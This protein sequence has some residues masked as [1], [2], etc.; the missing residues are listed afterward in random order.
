MAK[1]AADG[2][3]FVEWTQRDATLDWS[4]AERRLLEPTFYY[5]PPKT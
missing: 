1:W 2:A 3:A 5:R 4:E